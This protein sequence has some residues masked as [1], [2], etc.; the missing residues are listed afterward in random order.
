MQKGSTIP[1]ATEL[2][3]MSLILVASPVFAQGMR[4][5]ASW[6]VPGD[7]PGR[8]VTEEDVIDFCRAMWLN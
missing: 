5:G 3:P 4:D 2:K 6:Y 7:A 8:P 1:K